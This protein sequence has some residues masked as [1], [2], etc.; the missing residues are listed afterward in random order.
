MNTAHA[1]RL[2]LL[3]LG[4]TAAAASWPQTLGPGSHHAP[5][6]TG[7][8][9]SEL[10]IS[11]P[12]NLSASTFNVNMGA[13]GADRVI[14]VTSTLDHTGHTYCAVVCT[15]APPSRS[16]LFGIEPGARLTI[17]GDWSPPAGIDIRVG[18]FNPSGPLLLPS[19]VDVRGTLAAPPDGGRITVQ[20]TA[21]RLPVTFIRARAITGTWTA[22]SIPPGT[23]LVVT[24]TSI[25]LRRTPQ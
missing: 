22:R 24:D 2:A 7:R 23:Q 17:T 14:T 10:T 13:P 3:L 1:Y 5:D 9:R 21:P 20:G 16:A 18:A 4:L 15:I 8:A 12:V 11:G 6:S 19:V 25:S